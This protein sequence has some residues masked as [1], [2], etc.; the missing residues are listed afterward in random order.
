[1]P[2]T[3]STFVAAIMI[4][5][6]IMVAVQHQRAERGEERLQLRDQELSVASAHLANTESVLVATR[7]QLSKV[8]DEINTVRAS[9][10]R[11]SRRTRPCVYA[12]RLTTHLFTALQWELSA[13]VQLE[14]GN[15]PLA[16]RALRAGADAA[17]AADKVLRRS[18]VHSI[19]ALVRACDHAR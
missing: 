11:I 14:G 6:M 13:N 10:D 4:T 17:R 9:H 18:D 19:P 3:I 1:M 8:K 12:V 7:R 5:A 15:H 16:E 2:G